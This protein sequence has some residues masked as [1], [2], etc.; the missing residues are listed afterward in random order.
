MLTW[1]KVSKNTLLF[2]TRV[3]QNF[4]SIMIMKTW[5]PLAFNT[6]NSCINKLKLY[7]KDKIDLFF[8]Y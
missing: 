8:W 7:T 6:Q 4:A 5:F 1:G 2:V 3:V